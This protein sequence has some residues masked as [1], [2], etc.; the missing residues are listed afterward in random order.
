M[1]PEQEESLRRQ[2]T[3]RYFETTASRSF[4]GDDHHYNEASRQLRHR[5]RGWL[6]DDRSGRVLDIGCGCGELLYLL[7]AEGFRDTV[8]VDLSREQLARASEFVGS[9]LHLRDAHA[10][11]KEQPAGSFDAIIALNFLEHLPDEQLLGIMTESRRCLREGG[12]LIGMVPNGVSNFGSLTRYW[13]ITH[14]RA[15][16]PNSLRQL[17]SLTGYSGTEFRELG[18]IPHGARSVVRWLLWKVTRALIAFRLLVELGSTKDGV[19]TMDMLV[20]MKR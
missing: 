20:R 12:V 14:T 4:V 8:G 16:T 13:D 19:Y 6:P 15:F 18:P 2:V 7:E 3:E 5:L 9:G 10:F 1:N 17:A 11:L